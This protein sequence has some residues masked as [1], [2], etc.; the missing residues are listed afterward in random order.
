MFLVV[1]HEAASELAC[2]VIGCVMKSSH[3]GIAVDLRPRLGKVLL[4]G[5]RNR[6]IDTRIAAL[7][8]LSFF[9]FFYTEF[10]PLLI[11]EGLLEDLRNMIEVDDAVIQTQALVLLDCILANE[12]AHGSDEFRC[13]FA[14]LDGMTSIEDVLSSDVEDLQCLCKQF[15]LV[16]DAV[17]EEQPI[18]DQMR[19]LFMQ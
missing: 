15:L 2:D 19:Y 9:A 10:I 16:W 3:D 18:S 12:N 17:L 14:E 11:G 13:M 4:E 7:N 8:S 6:P 1:F 5:T